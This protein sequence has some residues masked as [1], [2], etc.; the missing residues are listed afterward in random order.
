MIK[1]NGS[2]NKTAATT[3][4]LPA[5]IALTAFVVACYS[6]TLNAETAVC[7]PKVLRVLTF[8]DGLS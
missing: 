5:A 2:P 3:R 7:P 6:N 1:R 4:T 8:S